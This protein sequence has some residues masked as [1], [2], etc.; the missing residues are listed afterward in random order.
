MWVYANPAIYS[1]SELTGSSQF[2]QSKA[3]ANELL[4]HM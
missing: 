3:M 4:S 2:L 1:G